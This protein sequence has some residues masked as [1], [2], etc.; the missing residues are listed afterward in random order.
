MPNPADIR[1]AAGFTISDGTN[2]I[3]CVDG[4]ELNLEANETEISCLGDTS[5]SP[6]VIDEQFIITSIGR[7]AALSGRSLLNDAG[8]NAVFTAANTGAEITLEYRYFDGSG[9]DLTGSFQ[10]FNF[11]GSKDQFA[12][13]F[14]AQFRVN[15]LV[16]VAAS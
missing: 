8:Q 6:P 13:S 10:N 15:T 14:T 4:W 9:Y 16:E 7:T 12:E 2:T 3:G 11:T 1:R 5:G